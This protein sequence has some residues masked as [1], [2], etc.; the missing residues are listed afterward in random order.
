MYPELLT[1]FCAREISRIT[2]I[3]KTVNPN[4]ESIESRYAIGGIAAERLAEKYGTPLYVYD[5]AEIERQYKRLD[6]VFSAV[7]HRRIHFAMKALSNINIL[8]LIR[9]LGGG[10]DAVSVNEARLALM[11]GFG[12]KD[13]VYTPNGVPM[14]EIDQAVDLGVQINIDSLET[15]GEFVARHPGVPVGIRIMPE[16]FA[17]G[18]AKISVGGRESKFGIPLPYMDRVEALAKEKGLVVNGVHLHTGSDIYDVEV[19]LEGAERVF[20]V[21]GRFPV[22]Y[23]D[24]GSGFKVPYR[25][26]EKGTD[27]EAVGEKLSERFNRFVRR[28]GREVRLLVEPGKFLV[29]GCG[30]LLVRADWVKHTPAARFVQVD[31]GLCHLLRPMM[32]DA[33]HHILNVSH[34]DGKPEEYNVTGYVCETDNFAVHRLLPQVRRGDLLA[35]LNAGAYGYTMASVYNSRFRPAQVLVKDGRDYLISRRE[36]LDDLLALQTDYGF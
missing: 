33:Y 17:G 2:P 24:F 19:F 15:L 1:Y 31:S 27:V 21:A 34:P 8:R 14:E 11:A 30:T 12:P 10:V 5:S 6:G 18:H 3:E 29:S 35:V 4:N 26:G 32:Y 28:T 20:G 7:E 25:P 36:T 22:E 13:I 23:I 16:L 9:G